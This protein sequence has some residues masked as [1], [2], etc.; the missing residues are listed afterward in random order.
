MRPLAFRFVVTGNAERLDRLVADFTGRGRRTVKDWLRAGIVRLDGRV[1]TG[2]EIPL[3]GSEVVVEDG[4]DDVAAATNSAAWRPVVETD[5][6]IAVAKPAGLHCVR[7]RTA[8]SLAELVQERYGDLTLVGDVADDGGLVHRIDRDT[9]GLVIV[10]RQ[11]RTWQRLRAAFGAGRTRKQYLALVAGSLDR[12]RDIELPLARRGSRMAVAG[13]HDDALEAR[14]HV[15]PLEG[16]EDWSLVLATMTTGA[17]HQV[18]VHLAAAGL[19]L[20]GDTV[21]GG[22]LLGGSARRG[23]HLHAMR[24]EID[25]EIDVSVGPPEDFLA[26][27]AA[28]R[29]APDRALLR[30]ADAA[31]TS[32]F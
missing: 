24:V 20:I 23:Q 11:R 22:P 1:A 9:S 19:P 3:A 10:A 12:T 4:S 21:Y 7:G 5:A 18:R 32:S 15:E 27:Y 31:P 28:L 16:C 13:R 26:A 14:T 17:M 8:G 6:W 25:E 29:R 2:S 30:G